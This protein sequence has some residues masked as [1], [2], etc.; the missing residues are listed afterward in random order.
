[1]VGK[2][3][4]KEAEPVVV[5]YPGG[6]DVTADK[7]SVRS[8]TCD[9]SE[10]GEMVKTT[11]SSVLSASESKADSESSDSTPGVSSS[12]LTTDPKL[13]QSVTKFIQAQ[14]DMMAAP[15]RVMAAQS[16]PSLPYFSGEG[17]LVGEGQL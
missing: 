8:G 4:E 3:G 1:M 9:K 6:G 15:T 16:L 5:T 2:A 11:N 13:V 14:T 17:N 7:S 10:R 12:K